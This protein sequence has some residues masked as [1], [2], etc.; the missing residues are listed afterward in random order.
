[1]KT[2]N[3][4]NL[5]FVAMLATG[6]CGVMGDQPTGTAFLHQG[7][8]APDGT[9]ASET[10]DLGF[11][12]WDAESEG[13]QVGDTLWLSEVEVVNGAFTVELDFGEDVVPG[14]E[15]WL[16]T[17]V[18]GKPVNPRQPFSLP[19][20]QEGEEGHEV[21]GAGDDPRGSIE[22]S[23]TKNCVAKFTGT[24][25]I[26]DSK[27]YEVSG[28]VGLRT[29]SPK[30]PLSVIGVVRAAQASDELEF[31]EMFHGGANAYLNWAGDGRLDFR[32]NGSNLASLRNDGRLGIGTSSPD[33]ELSVVGTLRGAYDMPESEYLEM[34]HGGVNAYLN[35][36][37]DGRLDFRYAGSTLASIA[38]DGS[39]GIA[40]V[41][42]AD[43]LHIGWCNG[44]GITLSGSPGETS[45]FLTIDNPD[46]SAPTVLTA[47]D[48]TAFDVEYPPGA[49]LVTVD[50]AGA[51]G[52]GTTTPGA[53][54]EVV[55]QVK[56]TGGTPG[57]GKV[58]TSDAAGLASW[59]L[60]SGS[61]DITAVYA[62]NGLTGGATSGDAHLNVGAGD[63]IDVSAN[64]V[65]VDVTDIAGAGLGEDGSNNLK[66]NTG[67]G[68]EING[69]AVKLKSAYSSGS[70]YDSRF[71]N[72]NAGEV[73]NADF[74]YPLSLSW[75]SSLG[76][77]MIEARRNIAAGFIGGAAL[78]GT[79]GG[80]MNAIAAYVGDG[81]GDSIYASNWGSGKAIEAWSGHGKD[82][83]ARFMSNSGSSGAG[84]HIQG[85]LTVTGTKSS[86]VETSA[87]MEALFAVESPEVEFCSSGEGSLVAGEATVRFDPLFAESVSPLVSVKVLVT[88]TEDCLGM[89]VAEKS[90]DGFTVRELGGGTSDATFDWFAIGTRKGYESPPEI[91]VEPLEFAAESE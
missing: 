9:P 88:P 13:V 30:R 43:H 63:G 15:L 54:L 73:T 44:N 45:P 22:G 35:W 27:V 26:G 83:V 5:V 3:L 19:Y 53:K 77:T 42:P 37:G 16:E 32:Y 47:R 59:Q 4:R 51:V 71:V 25:T 39:V 79:A 68:L 72:D 29:S 70:A 82:Y 65:A 86:V 41:A 84:V 20:E 74:S 69:D 81:G 28:K 61:G 48:E 7:R 6:P 12:L 55:G 57:A 31:V 58:L 91:S 17:V 33:V 76:N 11:S 23:G 62:D 67:T 78:G 80:G 89:Y 66:V 52:I 10:V 34:G 87:G 2:E 50:Q 21:Q 64:A 8:L 46:N 90:A 49:R 24:S 40:N 1:M 56:I 18:W 38:Q 85:Y 75:S 14:R 36:A 60:P